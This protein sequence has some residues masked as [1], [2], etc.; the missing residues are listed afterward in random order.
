MGLDAQVIALGPFS[1]SV[2]PALEYGP[3]YYKDVEHGQTIITNV[4][5]AGTSHDSHELA[6]A[7]GVG[8]MELGKH[9][10]NPII[11]STDELSK[12]FGEHNVAQFQLL[13]QHGFTFYFLPN[14]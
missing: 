12:I 10:L 7:F 2:L 4:F 14:A 9:Q 1:T 8:A 13:V 3:D 11:S 6:S 5:I